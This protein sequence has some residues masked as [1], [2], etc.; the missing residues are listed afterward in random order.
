[1]A[2][3]SGT[4]TYCAGRDLSGDLKEGIEEFN[5][6]NTGVTAK[7]FELPESADEQRS[8]LIQRHRAKSGVCDGF[9]S[10][11]VWTAEFASQKWL[12]DMTL[13]I[14]ARRSEF[15]PSTLETVNYDGKLWGAPRVTNA[16]LL[17]Y[18]TDTLK[19]EPTT[20][21]EAYELAKAA[22]PKGL[23]YQGAPYEGLTV[24][25]LELAFAAGG[26]VLSEDGKKS[27]FNN[28]ANVKALELMVDGI[29]DGAAPE[30]VTIYM[31]AAALR[32]FDAGRAAMMRNWPFAYYALNQAASQVRGR[33]KVISFPRFE[34]GGRAA[35]LGG[36]NMVISA[37][38]KNPA[39]M[40]K[41]IDFMTGP[42]RMKRNAVRY[43]LA[44]PLAATYED[45]SVQKAMPFS[46]TLK[47]SV[48]QAKSRP[49]S[50]VY[51]LI[52]EAI[53]NNVNAALGRSMTPADA[54][55]NADDQISK[56][57]HVAVG[58]TR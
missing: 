47:R 1:M 33:F 13:Y 55:K 38:A 17:F 9:E 2:N 54:V 50:P 26:K 3:A 24:N 18:R 4:V 41:L 43:S 32:A 34:G 19:K 45:P 8:Q 12:L 31:E 46:D 36:S 40:L 30:A 25:F 22:D 58:S 52:S 6:Q 11:V 42:E 28:P 37:F 15:I 23:V 5:R 14:Q 21:Q 35:V 7:L 27:E 53:Y 10:D 48:E 39:G 51:P 16:G 20:W 57:L 44:P 49:I 56:A 29:K